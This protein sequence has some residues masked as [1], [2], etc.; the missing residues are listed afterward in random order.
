VLANGIPLP[1][2]WVSP[3]APSTRVLGLWFPVLLLRSTSGG[4]SLRS[5][6]SASTLALIVFACSCAYVAHTAAGM[7]TGDWTWSRAC[8]L[9]PGSSFLSFLLPFSP[10]L[11]SYARDVD[12]GDTELSA[13]SM[14]AGE[15]F[16]A[17]GM[18]RDCPSLHLAVRTDWRSRLDS[19]AHLDM[20]SAR[21]TLRGAD[22]VG[23]LPRSPRV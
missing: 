20:L 7:A 6:R 2:A 22:I 16:E 4:L 12:R 17:R 18:T 10:P 19:E 3:S 13:V 23:P 5:S 21:M 11:V 1:P 14:G 9:S 15:P 8:L